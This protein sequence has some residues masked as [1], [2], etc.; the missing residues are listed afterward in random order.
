[1]VVRTVHY[2]R[3]TCGNTIRASKYIVRLCEDDK[4]AS[5]CGCGGNKTFV[6]GNGNGMYMGAGYFSVQRVHVLALCDQDNASTT[7]VEVPTFRGEH[8]S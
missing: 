3:N 6:D 2:T 1:M 7:P 8:R 5:R 4:I